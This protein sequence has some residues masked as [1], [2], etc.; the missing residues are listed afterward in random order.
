MGIPRLSIAG[1]LL[2]IRV[3]GGSISPADPQPVSQLEQAYT[4]CDQRS[5]RAPMLKTYKGSCHCGAVRYEADIDLAQGTGK[6]NCSICTKT[7]DWN[8]I[9]KPAAFR[10]IAGEDAVSD[11]R[12]GSKQGSH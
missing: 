6:C 10:L 4:R 1:M 9:I 2:K 3:V 7:R 8:A 11:Y 12:F 5:W